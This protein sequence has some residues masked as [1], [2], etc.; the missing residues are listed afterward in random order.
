MSVITIQIVQE[1]RY[2]SVERN[3]SHYVSPFQLVLQIAREI[4]KISQKSNKSM[5]RSYFCLRIFCYSMCF[6]SIV[7]NKVDRTS[8]G[9]M[10]VILITLLRYF[11][12]FKRGK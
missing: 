6:V 8:L 9:N 4:Q 11:K 1:H 3:Y 10:Q 12:S 7:R 2:H 5:R